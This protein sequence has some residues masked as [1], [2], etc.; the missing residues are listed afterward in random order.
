MKLELIHRYDTEGRMCVAPFI[1]GFNVWDIP[2]KQ[3]TEEVAN[4]IL[5]AY[6]LGR[7]TARRDFEASIRN[8]QEVSVWNLK[9]PTLE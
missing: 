2:K 4:A 9:W 7:I 3:W 8:I 1:D 5:H 6:N